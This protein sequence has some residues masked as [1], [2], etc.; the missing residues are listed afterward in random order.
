MR[1]A[2]A[3]LALL[4]LV[5]LA[6]DA[7]AENWPG[8]RGLRGD[9]TS[10]AKSA[11][12][13]W[14][15]ATGENIAWKV[16]VPGSGHSSPIIWDDRLFLTACNEKTQERLLACLDRRTGKTLWQQTVLK[17]PLETKHS[18]NSYASGTPAT[19]GHL[20]FVSFLEVDGSTIDAPNVGN[21]RPV[22]PGRLVVAAYDFN[23]NQKWLVK[24]G[25][26]IS[27]HGFCTSPVLYQNLVIV[28][29]DH[30]GKSYLAAL[31][32]QTGE[33]VWNVPRDH[34]IRSYVTP[35]VREI[36]GRTQL[37]LSGSKHIASLDPA[38]GKEHWRIEGPTEQFVASMVYDGKLLFM[39]AG[40]PTY[41]VMGI[42][43]GGSGD[44]TDSHVAWHE[45]N[46]QCYVPSPVVTGGYLVVA[47][48]RGTA[49]C[50][51]AASG[52]RL[53]QERLGKHF[54]ASLITAGG[55]V[56]VIA[57][58]GKT[59]IVRPGE[60]LDL[61]AENELGECCYSSPAIAHNQLYIRGEKHLFCIGQTK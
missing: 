39:A 5:S 18:L 56:Y 50:Y 19:D 28:N 40:F 60:E 12:T 34:G 32:K 15:G 17:A 52:E 29:G 37:I 48:D 36:E 23:G 25:E 24:V 20:V 58:D 14:N 57:D 30:D 1:S 45:T 3:A 49:N 59:A 21:K 10:A 51:D 41:H 11:P 6:A 26:F 61:V 38:S 44:V 22:T 7:R 33:T 4:S 47:D 35:I 46:A 53:W 55:L 16:P 9:G 8:W 13:Q 42:R 31:D 54:S 2:F 27:A 43:P